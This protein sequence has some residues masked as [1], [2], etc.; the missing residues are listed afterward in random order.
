MLKVNG[1]DFYLANIYISPNGLSPRKY[2]S[3]DFSG[4]GAHRTLVLVQFNAYDITWYFTR[5]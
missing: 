1:R 3:G 2:T 5:G 4:I